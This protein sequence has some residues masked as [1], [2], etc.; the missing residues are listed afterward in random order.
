[1][2][3]KVLLFEP[4]IQPVGVEIISSE[5]QI[6]MAPNGDEE[7][8]ISYLSAGDISAAVTRVEKIT[9]RVIERAYALKVIG[10]HGVGVDNIDVQ[11]ATEN[12]IIVVNALT[13]NYVST[14]EHAVMFMLALS[15]RLLE[16]DVQ[17]RKGNFQFREKFYPTEINGKILF[18]LGLGRIGSEVAKKCRLAFNMEVLACD[19]KLSSVEMASIGV[20]KV[21]LKTGLHN[22][23]FVS[24]HVPLSQETSHLIGEKELSLMKKTAVLLNLSR[25][26]VIDQNALVRALK[27]NWIG[28]AG[29]DVFDPE[30]PLPD[31]PLLELPNVILTPH[32]AGDTYEAKQRCSEIIANEVLCVLKGRLPNS[33]VN[34]EVFSN[35]QFLMRW[36]EDRLKIEK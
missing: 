10:Q 20:K 12:G 3:S 23:D 13:S 8:I 16:T 6:I 25:G 34:P 36:N 14:A 5:A 1:M 28:G 27:E 30:P 19:P 17:V 9:R 2:M 31:D 22:S 11:A 33:I 21:D 24:I 29:L 26:P 4:T 15:R 35:R 18:I 7:T 32:F